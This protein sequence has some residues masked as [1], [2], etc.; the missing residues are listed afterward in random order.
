LSGLRHPPARLLGIT[1]WSQ[2]VGNSI[3][4][5]E[6]GKLLTEFDAPDGAI[7]SLHGNDLSAGRWALVGETVCVRYRGDPLPDRSRR[8][9]RDLLRQVGFGYQ[10]LQG[11]P[12]NL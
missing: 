5:R 12:K 4:G 2:V 9:Q 3:T 6:E 8:R 7:K 11:N 10:I 1:A